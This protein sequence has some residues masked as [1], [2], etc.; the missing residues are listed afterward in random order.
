MARFTVELNTHYTCPKQVEV[1]APTMVEAVTK[2]LQDNHVEF[3]D[4]PESHYEG[5]KRLTVNVEPHQ[6][7]LLCDGEPHGT[8][9]DDDNCCAV[10]GE[11]V[12]A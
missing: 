12:E 6:D 11:E 1:E 2:A 4:A 10:C 5:W 3:L 9:R 7:S 8:Y